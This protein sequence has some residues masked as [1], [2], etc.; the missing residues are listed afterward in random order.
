MFDISWVHN[1]NN[2]TLLNYFRGHGIKIPRFTF[3]C[4]R[5]KVL[6]N[7]VRLVFVNCSYT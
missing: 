3:F 6:N 5:L 7:S 4:H 2:N 1:S